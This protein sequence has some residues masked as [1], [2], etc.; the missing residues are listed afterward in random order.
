MNVILGIAALMDVMRKHVNHKSQFLDGQLSMYGIAHEE[1]FERSP[2]WKHFQEVIN[3]SEEWFGMGDSFEG[4]DNE[5]DWAVK[6]KDSVI[7]LWSDWATDVKKFDT[8]NP[9]TMTKDVAFEFGDGLPP[10]DDKT[11]TTCGVRDPRVHVIG[12]EPGPGSSSRAGSA[13]EAAAQT[14]IM[15][16]QDPKREHLISDSNKN[17]HHKRKLTAT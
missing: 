5:I 13:T 3:N 7:G 4:F 6:H 14:S 17:K 8:L 2:F 16:K 15:P 11:P 10:D 12:S 9:G 1:K